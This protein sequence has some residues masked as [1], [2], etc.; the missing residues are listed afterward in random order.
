MAIPAPLIALLVIVIIGAITWWVLTQF[1][2]PEPLNKVVHILFVVIMLLALLFYVLLPML[3]G[4][5]IKI[6]DSKADGSIGFKVAEIV[7][8]NRAG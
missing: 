2:L 4:A 5:N 6:R 7:S 1:T 8:F 3:G